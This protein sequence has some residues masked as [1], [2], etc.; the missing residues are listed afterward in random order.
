[1]AYELLK[2][3]HI[4]GAVLIGAGLIGVWMAD[5]RSRQLTESKPFVEAV[6]NIAVFYDGLVL[7]GA[8]LLGA[9][10]LWM[11]VAY[12]DGWG[13]LKM[14]WLVGMVGWF[15]FEFIEGNTVTRIFFMRLRRLT[16]EA[17]EVGHFTPEL[18]HARGELVPSFTHFSR[19]AGAVPDHRPGSDQADNVDDVPR[20]VDRRHRDRNAAHDRH[21]PALSMGPGRIRGRCQWVVIIDSSAAPHGAAEE[22]GPVTIPLDAHNWPLADTPNAIMWIRGAHYARHF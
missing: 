8:L 15:L 14:P 13:F 9:S 12:Y 1:M 10:G 16:R 3:A 17:L 2:F 6:R 20:R 21:P 18:Q 5:L 19:P 22:T 11:I 7:P 4:L